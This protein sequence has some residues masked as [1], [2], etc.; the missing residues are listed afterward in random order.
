MMFQEIPPK[1]TGK[2]ARSKAH[3][4]DELVAQMKERPGEWAKIANVKYR[5]GFKPFTSRGAKIARRLQKD[6]TWD[7]YASWPPPTTEQF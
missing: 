4:V 2:W 6:G 3:E 7:V 5:G 1:L